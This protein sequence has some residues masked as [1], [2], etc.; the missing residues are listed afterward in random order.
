ML[1]SNLNKILTK[2]WLYWSNLTNVNTLIKEKGHLPTD[3]YP[4]SIPF[5]FYK[6]QP[7][8]NRGSNNAFASLS[9][10][11]FS[12]FGFQVKGRPN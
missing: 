6:F 12:F 7:A 3:K 10:L 2:S 11:N 5:H 9:F 4:S 1:K 8:L